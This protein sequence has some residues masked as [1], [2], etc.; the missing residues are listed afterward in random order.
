MFIDTHKKD[1]RIA[2]LKDSSSLCDLDDDFT[3]VFKK[4]L[5]ERYQHRPQC[6][7]SMCLAEFA[8]N[9][10]TDYRVSEDDDDDDDNNDVL[11]SFDQNE[12]QAS[13]KIT[14]TDRFGKNE[15]VPERGYYKI[16]A[17]ISNPN[18]LTG[19]EQS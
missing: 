19:I 8:A 2:V 6:L 14:L 12:P 7:R 9:Y 18:Q 13:S 5:I 16:Q 3:D 11:P 4:S 15:K 10:A 1:E 17:I